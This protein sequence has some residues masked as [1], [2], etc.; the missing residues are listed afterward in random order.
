MPR[1]SC[2]LLLSAVACG[3]ANE[4]APARHPPV[5]RTNA[6]DDAARVRALDAYRFADVP[7]GTFGPYVADTASGGV[8]A[9]AARGASGARAWYAVAFDADGKPSGKPNALGAA[10]ADV[11]LAIV[12]PSTRAAD[13][14]ASYVLL[15]THRDAGRSIIEARRLSNNAELIAGPVTLAEVA[16]EVIWLDLVPTDDRPLAL[17]GTKQGDAADLFALPV[18]GPTPDATQPKEIARAVRAWQ[19]ASFG[20]SAAVG[21]VLPGAANARGG[22]VEVALLDVNGDVTSR[23]P[24]SESQTA[25]GDLDMVAAGSGLLLAW[26]DRRE[27]ESRV[28]L[29]AVDRAG[30][31]TRQASAAVGAVGEQA[32]VRLVPPRD[33]AG[34]ADSAWENL[35]ER[36]AKGRTIELAA[37]DANGSVSAPRVELRH[38]ATDSTPELTA[39]ARGLAA[40]TLAPACRKGQDCSGAPLLPTFVELDRKLELLVSEPIKVT[41][42][43]GE[44]PDLAWGLSCAHAQCRVLAAQATDPAPVYSVNL[45]GVSLD[46]QPASERATPSSPPRAQ[47]LQALASLEPLA[48]VTLTKLGTT[49]LAAWIT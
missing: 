9:W 45:A 12:E 1:W 22:H 48:G 18:P 8:A 31:I 23:V 29:A 14:K 34:P 42:L 26:S 16:P 25:E 10:P 46:W 7:A 20:A 13:S 4:Q 47:S 39:S 5:K 19:A 17:F 24:V 6:A 27:V 32:L 37:V 44:A 21:M 2:L 35:L 43:A 36:P 49:S 30:K 38:A 15:S 11:G 40:L 28:Y 41:P 33:A 3:G